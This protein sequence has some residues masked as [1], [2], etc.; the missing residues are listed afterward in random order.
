MSEAPKEIWFV[1]ADLYE[2]LEAK[3]AK[4]EAIRGWKR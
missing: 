1:R 2:E 4:A 3:L